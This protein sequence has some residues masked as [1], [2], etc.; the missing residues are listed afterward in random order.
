MAKRKSIRVGSATSKPGSWST[1]TLTLGHYPD[2]PITT[3]VNILSGNEPGPVLWVQS[4]IHGAEIGGAMALLRLFKKI[5]ADRMKGHIVGVMA[6]SPT[7][8]RAQGRLTPYDGENMNRL[9]PG[10]P[11]GPHS[12]QTAAALFQTATGVADVMMDLHSGGNEAVVPFY[13]LYF[14]DGSPASQEAR[15]LAE[16][17]GSDVVW[18][19]RDTW[20][21]GAMFVNFT[22]TGRPGI[23][24]ECGGGGSLPE[25]HIRN[26][27]GAIEGV[28]KAMGILPGRPPRQK[29][30]TVVRDCE[31][32]FNT[33]GGYFLPAVDVGDIVRKGAVIGRVMDAHGEVIE[34]IRSPNGPAYLAALVKPYLP[35]HS[36]AM[37]AE[38]IEVETDNRSK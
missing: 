16:S 20:L 21:D 22:R 19:S 6:A 36:G 13:G 1:G 2:A 15:R 31:L 33:R 7:A 27:A 3:P 38:C 14:D 12:R 35:I 18:A 28:A 5:K 34:E 26:F 32:V 37:V 25:E 11:N 8:F 30:F 29:K 4:A 24:V 23:I 9:F 10:D 17:V